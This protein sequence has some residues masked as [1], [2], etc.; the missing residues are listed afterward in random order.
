MSIVRVYFNSTEK[1]FTV[2][3]KESGKWRKSFSTNDITLGGVKFLCSHK[4]RLRVI[5]TKKKFVHAYF[6]GTILDDQPKRLKNLFRLAAESVP[7][8]P[9]ITQ[10]TYNPYLFPNSFPEEGIGKQKYGE[11]CDRSIVNSFWNITTQK[12]GKW[13]GVLRLRVMEDKKPELIAWGAE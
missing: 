4:S 1:N 5:A 12:A 10:I 6:E 11:L 13:C 2:L 9:L 8:D 3:T 7:Q